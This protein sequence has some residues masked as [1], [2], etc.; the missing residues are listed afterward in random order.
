MSEDIGRSERA[1]DIK[2][3]IGNMLT[4]EQKAR[5]KQDAILNSLSR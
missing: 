2:G 4:D 3:K 5:A 1:L